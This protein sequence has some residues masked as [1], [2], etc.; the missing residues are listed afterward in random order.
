MR[1]YFSDRS[2]QISGERKVSNIGKSGEDSVNDYLSMY[3]DEII[4]LSGI[5]ILMFMV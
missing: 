5:N 1:E 2:Y 3:D 4:N